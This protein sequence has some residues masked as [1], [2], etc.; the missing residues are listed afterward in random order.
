MADLVYYTMDDGTKVLFETAEAD[1]VSLHAGTGHMTEKDGGPLAE[2][3]SGIAKATQRI[4][5][6]MK[7]ALEP[8][9]LSVEL[10]IKVAG[11]LNVWFFAKNQAEATIKVT[12]TWKKG[13]PMPEPSA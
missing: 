2:R 1:L 4:A 9:E 6:A 13:T 10:G 5:A 11:E 8:D 7:N 3:L 12:G